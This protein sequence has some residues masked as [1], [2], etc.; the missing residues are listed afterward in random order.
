VT[1]EQILSAFPRDY[2]AARD[3]FR[4]AATEAGCAVTSYETGD[5]GP[6]GE[7]LTIDVAVSQAAIGTE[8]AVILSSGL[9]GVEAP[10]GS[11]VQVAAL[12]EISEGTLRSDARLVLVHALNP[13]G[14]AWSRRV[15]ARNV[16]LN[17]AFRWP[18]MPDPPP[19]GPYGA[20]D[21]LLNPRRR[22]SSD[23]F[24]LRLVA[25]AL[26]AGPSTLK[27]AIA[28]GQRSYPQGLFYAGAEAPSLQAFFER[29][30]PGWLAGATTAVHLDFHTGLGRRNHAALIID[31]P[32]SET[33]RAW[34]TS[35]AGAHVL[36]ESLRDDK[37]YTAI[38]SLG[39]WCVARGFATR[40]RFA[41]AE[42]GTFGG[43]RIL[44]GLRA[45]NQAHYWSKPGDDVTVAAKAR[46]RALFCPPESDWRVR[47]VRRALALT[48]AV[49]GST[50]SA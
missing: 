34:W 18:G 42:F 46:L 21:A 35:R 40:Y 7:A 30:L 8:T 2:A 14:F 5:V 49:S 20:I 28:A 4:Q 44:A 47:A 41:F 27:R 38:G 24:R 48:G 29:E 33:E 12:R 1:D 9:H 19:D 31:Y 10:F 32:L 17:R 43:P 16:D 45:E 22:P 39:Q 6:L 26:R 11:A 50:A 13:W 23:L 15:D 25:A 37:A 3:G 36:S